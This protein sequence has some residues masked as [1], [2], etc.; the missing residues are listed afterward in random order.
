MADQDR[1]ERL[2][3]AYDHMLESIGDWVQEVED[4]TVPTIEK[5]LDAAREK[6]TELNELTR[7]EAEK[8]GDYVRRDLLHLGEHLEDKDEDI[9][10]WFQ[11]DM[12]LIETK[13]AD[14]FSSVADRTTIELERL[15]EIASLSEYWNTGEITGPG[16]LEC[17]QCGEQLH[18]NKT[19]HI[20]P[21]PKCHATSFK[22]L[23]GQSET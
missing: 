18:F 21:C 20:P 1:K 22:R 11:I 8:V 2:A 7:E 12:S 19:G 17:T 13:L 10:S 15:R 14:M 6:A 4:V 16:V 9:K 23:S 3:Q 5:A